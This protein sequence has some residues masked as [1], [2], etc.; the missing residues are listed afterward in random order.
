VAKCS[1]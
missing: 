1:F